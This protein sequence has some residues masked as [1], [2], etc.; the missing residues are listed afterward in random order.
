MKAYE[1]RLV[2]LVAAGLA[3]GSMGCNFFKGKQE[4]AP[5]PYVAPVSVPSSTSAP[6]NVVDGYNA[7]DIQVQFPQPS[8]KEPNLVRRYHVSTQEVTITYTPKA[9]SDIKEAAG[10]LAYLRGGKFDSMDVL[11]LSIVATRKDGLAD[12][13]DGA[14]VLTKFRNAADK[15]ARGQFPEL[16]DASSKSTIDLVCNNY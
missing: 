8:Q 16:K 11:Q 5:A 4:Q 15:K 10:L 7:T 2:G 12:D 14:F 13:D 1:S 6:I 3:L 9:F